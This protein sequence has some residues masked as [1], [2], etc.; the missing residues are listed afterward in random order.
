MSPEIKRI[1]SE[2]FKDTSRH[3][4]I[5]PGVIEE[6]R[7]FLQVP[8]VAL[9]AGLFRPGTISAQSMEI[10]SK[11]SEIES[12]AKTL[13]TM[14]HR[15]LDFEG[16]VKEC[17]TLAKQ[18]AEDSS[19]NEDAHIFRMSSMAARLQLSSVPKGK[20]SAF[21][22]LNPPVELGPIHR[23]APLIIIQWR[24][25]P[26]ATLPAHNHNPADVLT[27]CLEGECRVRH[28]DIV[29]DAPE[30]SSKKTFLIRETQNLLLTPGR[31]SS[32][33]TTRDNIHTFQAGKEGAWGIDI[34][35]RLPGDKKFSFLE[36]SS[37]PRDADKRIFEAA[38][39]KL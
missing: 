8:M 19:L 29:G 17:A 2:S 13:S 23:I 7:I 5:A 24:M 34:N 9:I 14:N 21:G 32:L 10:V 36:F 11:V 15:D 30:Y 16:F 1:L 4:E 3:S 22:G 28:F 31:M 6:R 35:T 20:L 37:K 25:A 18:A 38:W 33:S 12:Y 39:M 26:G 27:V